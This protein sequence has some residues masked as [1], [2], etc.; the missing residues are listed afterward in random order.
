[1]YDAE[2]ELPACSCVPFLIELYEHC[3]DLARNG[4]VIPTSLCPLLEETK[5]LHREAD[6][7]VAILTHA[8]GTQSAASRQLEAPR[9][10]KP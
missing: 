4:S 9:T 10:P 2:E 7:Q 8:T 3:L 6:R 5:T 1:M